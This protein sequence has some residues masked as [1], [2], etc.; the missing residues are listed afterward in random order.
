MIAIWT[1]VHGDESAKHNI[2]TVYALFDVEY[3]TEHNASGESMKS[4]GP[5]AM[6]TTKIGK[7]ASILNYQSQSYSTMKPYH[8][9][10]FVSKF[11]FAMVFF[12]R[13]Q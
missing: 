10:I 7:N 11:R 13:Y 12:C 1:V 3:G 2:A 4:D 8:R 6:R 5:A 9:Y